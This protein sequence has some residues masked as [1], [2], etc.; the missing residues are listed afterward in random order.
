MNEDGLTRYVVEQIV[1]LVR[2][3]S[4]TGYTQEAVQY[5]EAELDKLKV[6][7]ERTKRGS[8]IATLPG[9]ETGPHR[10]LA[11]HVDTLGAMIKEINREGE[12]L[13]TRVGS[14]SLNSVEGEY[15]T[16]VTGDGARFRGTILFEKPSVHVYDS[17]GTVERKLENMRIRLDAIAAGDKGVESLGIRVGDYVHFD[18][19]VELTETGFV[20]AR[21]L[22]DKAGVAC[23]LGAIKAIAESGR[24]PRLETHFYFSTSE[25]VGFGASAGIPSETAEL[26]AVDMGAVGKGQKSDEYSVCICAKDTTGPFDFSLRQRLIQFCRRDGIACKVDVYPFYGSDAAVAVRA[27]LDTITGLI[28]P[29]IDASHSLERTHR[30]ALGATVRL[31]VAY[32]ECEGELAHPAG[33]P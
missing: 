6:G 24:K 4:P 25:E 33:R 2:I 9:R 20:K 29:G 12:L 32:L 7:H 10:T 1:N 19:R 22:D 31:I 30:Q 13:L 5:L 28:G 16:I 14:Y 21:H 3:P 17:V 27:G 11:G 23:M 15:C 26:I 18:P 8:L